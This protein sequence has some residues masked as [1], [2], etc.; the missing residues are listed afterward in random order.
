[1]ISPMVAARGMVIAYEP[2]KRAYDSIVKRPGV[3]S[4]ALSPDGKTFTQEDAKSFASS[5]QLVFFCA[6]YEGYDDRLNNVFDEQYSLG[7]FVI[8]GAEIACAAL[9]DASLR[10]VDGVLG[11]ADSLLNESYADGLLDYPHY[12]RPEVIDGHKV[13]DV[14]LSGDHKAIKD[15]RKG[16]S[17]LRTWQKRKDLLTNGSV[18][19]HD[20]LQLSDILHG[21]QKEDS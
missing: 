11:N 1:M 14:L 12:T 3:R 4:I 13:P 9:I 5:E 17:L 8:S 16:Q 10:Y 2:V 7:D 15:W 21:F 19:E 20:I 6:R 18:S